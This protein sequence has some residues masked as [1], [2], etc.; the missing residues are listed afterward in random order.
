MS[1]PESLSQDVIDD[2]KARLEAERTA[3][4]KAWAD[5]N[6]KPKPKVKSYDFRRPDKFSKE[7][8]L[9][10]Q[11]IHET[12]A[13][14]STTTFSAMMRSLVHVHVASVDQLTYEEFIRSIPT[15]T[16]IAVVSMDSLKGQAILEMDHAISFA[17]IERLLGGGEGKD[18]GLD[19]G[20][21]KIVRAL[22]DIEHSIMEGIIVRLLG[23][24]REAWT[25]I[26]D[27]R[28]RLAQIE[29]MP[30]FAQ[31]VP[32]SE[33]VVLIT[34]E[35]KIGEVEGMMNLAL[36]YMTI[37]PIVPRLSAAYWYSAV[38]REQPKE[39]VQALIGHIEGLEVP[40]E[41]LAEAS[42]LPL[43]ELGGLKRGSLLRV[44]GLDAGEATFR[45]GGKLLFRMKERER[46]W[47]EP[48]S[49]RILEAPREERLP[50]LEAAEEKHESS[51][52]EAAF[53]KALEE[54]QSGIGAGLSGIGNGIKALLE[55]QDE[56]TDQFALAPAKPEDSES[57]RPI[58]RKRPF[59]FVARAD[60]SHV[61]G[62][63]QQE[64]PQ[65]IALILSYLEP[66]VASSLLGS[67]PLDMQPELAM[68]I[69]LMGRTMPEVLR[70]VERVLEKKLSVVSS[71]AY[72]EAGGME[73]LVE[74]LNM[75]DRA[76]ERH[77]VET[78]E[79]LSPE[80]AEEVKKRMF[81][82][83][84][85]VLLG[86]ETLAKVVKRSDEEIFLRAMKAV[87]DRARES[88][89]AL[90]P[91]DEAERLKKRLAETGKIRLSDVDA[92]QA[93]IIALIREMEESG[94][95]VIARPNE[96]VE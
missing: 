65:C 13:R 9:T 14:L 53:R 24:L 60:S 69:A 40:V 29:T 33:M 43:R 59:D 90:L 28:P 20:A 94:E 72:M 63:L 81:V 64:H 10:V 52:L 11:N 77:V 6:K 93:R 61:L 8:I 36:P 83:E 5:R 1:M 21:Y 46:R 37:E 87:D 70:E 84:D 16:T 55:K 45:M 91:R 88:I 3:S 12:F 62:I 48:P 89:W 76:T 44:P 75:S 80:L 25:Q 19:R 78:L 31:I 54:F 68:R 96:T 92:A 74:I 51:E 58:E 17:I 82:F 15:P 56:M 39:A 85:I 7:Q 38:R 79:K 22:T 27:L 18:P 67:L 71:E 42:A 35:T 86:R 32:P 57:A 23:N 41:V 26:L 2:M 50:V 47:R 30:Q 66:S 34:L 4:D 73:G 95:I 49:Y